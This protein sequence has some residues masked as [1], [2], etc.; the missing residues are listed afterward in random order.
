LPATL[1]AGL[2]LILFFSD[3]TQRLDIW[4]LDLAGTL[5]KS[6][7]SS[8]V[9]I[10]EIDSES[11]REIGRWPWPR[12]EHAR[13]IERL[14][15]AGT[16]ALG[17][18]VLFIDADQ[19]D[20]AGDGRLEEALGRHGRVVLPLTVEFD[21]RLGLVEVYPIPRFSIAAAALGHVD[22]TPDFADGVFR[23]LYL[24]AGL[25]QPRWPAVPLAML[26]VERSEVWTRIGRNGWPAGPVADK[27]WVRDALT[28]PLFVLPLAEIP[29]FRALDVFDGRVGK[30]ELQGR[31]VLVGVTAEGL[32]QRF[33]ASLA[34]N[35]MLVSGLELDALVLDSLLR[36]LWLQRLP[37]SLTA[38]ACALL[39]FLTA[40]GTVHPDSRHPLLKISAGILAIVVAWGL[41]LVWHLW[42]P[43]VPALTAL[44]L[45]FAIRLWLRLK[46]REREA[47]H[48]Y[49]TRIANRRRFNQTLDLEWRSG[50][51]SRKPLALILLD[52]DYFK[53]YN[54]S[55]GHS[56]GDTVLSRLSQV[57]AKA[58]RRPRDLAAR[59]GG[60]EFAV[61]LPET[62]AEQAVQLAERIRFAVESLAIPHAASGGVPFVTVS[63]GAASLVPHGDDHPGSLI[64][65]AD[66]A[67]YR[68]KERG[69]NRVELA[70]AAGDEDAV[71][72][73]KQSSGE[74]AAAR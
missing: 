33:T 17:Y 34:G 71:V 66:M 15:E 20:A 27:G 48:D 3:T 53:R 43:V 38:L 65:L 23:G 18:E 73:M 47:F 5:V 39:V 42:F 13:L 16:R 49:L 60:E 54:D 40:L 30:Q 35:T 21:A 59:Y 22:R 2:C 32:A 24:Y 45:I 28:L 70:P 51:R 44:L 57:I 14:T 19:T 7:R 8:P 1:L 63:L 74:E 61:L 55:Y 6:D 56:A 11:L 37:P 29:R 31:Y 69:R 36:G 62:G 50:L 10:V 52:V 26:A 72:A 4:L 64:S 41:S 67:L 58:A 25:G 9:A 68:A 46:R 12:A